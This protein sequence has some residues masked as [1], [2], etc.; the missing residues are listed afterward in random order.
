M[1]ELNML[2]A[3]R[4]ALKLEMERDQK[5]VILGQDIG[6]NG[7]VFRATEGLQSEF[8]VRRVID[9]P[10]AE[11][12]I[13]GSALG[14]AISGL[15]PIA[16]I[17]F[18]GFAHQA[19]H[20]ITDQV[21]R[22]RFRSQGHYPLQMTIR[23]PFGGGVR[24]P[25]LHSDALEA[26]FTHCPGLKVVLPSNPYDA[27]GL[28]LSS[29]RDPDPVLFLEPLRGYRLVRGEVPDGDYTVPLGSA[30]VIRTGGDVTLIAWSACVQLALEASDVL[31]GMGIAT[32]VVDLR[33][34][35]PLDVQTLVDS[36]IKTGRAVVIEEASLTGGFGAEIVATICEEALYD[37][38]A[39]VRRV[40]SPDCPYPLP[41]SERFYL[42]TV[43]DVVRAVQSTLEDN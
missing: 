37:L 29:I 9:T 36:V 14:L 35:V 13:V 33:S 23:A 7:G 6:A 40:S 4:G 24:T 3:I 25:E 28:L 10:L 1:T 31:A 15:V 2:E 19:Y 20:Q 8:G 11:G 43:D 16:E 42:P 22:Y 27:K 34:L 26:Q 32:T 21:A 5:T 17:Q 12:A 38:Q 39:P 18:L 30:S 41:G